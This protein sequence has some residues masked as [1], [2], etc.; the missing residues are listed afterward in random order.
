MNEEFSWT[1]QIREIV[2][3]LSRNCQSR[4]LF[5]EY[6]SH[7]LLFSINITLYPF[8]QYLFCYFSGLMS[9]SRLENGEL[10]IVVFCIWASLSIE[11][12]LYVV[13]Q[14]MI[15]AG[16]F[17]FK[18]WTKFSQDFMGSIEIKSFSNVWLD[19]FYVYKI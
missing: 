1:Q 18:V 10:V 7:F 15:K 3:L 6:N 9:H 13:L 4:N 2:Q 17:L 11:I 14:N 16:D 8:V 5:P 12:K 19:I